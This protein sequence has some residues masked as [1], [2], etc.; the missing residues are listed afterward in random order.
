MP[1]CQIRSCSMNI[2]IFLW[3]VFLCVNAKLLHHS[4][5]A[6]CIV[7]SGAGEIFTESA[8]NQWKIASMTNQRHMFNMK[9]V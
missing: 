3:D 8:L 5:P 1:T 4:T 7:T 9:F 2:P 6:V